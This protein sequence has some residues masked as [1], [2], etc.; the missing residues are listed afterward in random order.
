MTAER[1]QAFHRLRGMLKGKM[2]DKPFAE[3]WV[4]QKREELA[5]EE[6][7]LLHCCDKQ[8]ANTELARR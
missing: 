2:G 3:W 1:Q 4:V 7:K 6:A 8:K 5:L